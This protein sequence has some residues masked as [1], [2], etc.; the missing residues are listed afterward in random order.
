VIQTNEV[1][2]PVVIGTVVTSDLGRACSYVIVTDTKF[3]SV[4]DK[5]L[6]SRT[7]VSGSSYK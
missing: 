1:N 2:V 7:T 6:D 3:T 4:N 5:Q